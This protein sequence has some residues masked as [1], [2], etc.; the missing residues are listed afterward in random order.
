MILEQGLLKKRPKKGNAEMSKT[1]RII[2]LAVAAALIVGACGS[3]SNDNVITTE[4]DPAPVRVTT[5]TTDNRAAKAALCLEA[6]EK[7]TEGLEAISTGAELLP[8][9]SPAEQ[10][11]FLATA[12]EFV[13][14]SIETVKSCADLAPSEAA[15]ALSQLEALESAIEQAERL[16]G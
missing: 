3:G 4:N 11:E 8:Y 16:V 13:G 7:I 9:V 2:G 1:G 10:R 15:Y 12:K 14:V 5:P 6:T